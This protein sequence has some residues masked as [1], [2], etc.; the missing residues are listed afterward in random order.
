M[1]LIFYLLKMVELTMNGD[2]LKH[3]FK[4]IPIK[5]NYTMFDWLKDRNMSL[6]KYLD[7]MQYVECAK[8]KDRTCANFDC[9]NNF[10]L[11]HKIEK[12]GDY[13][14]LKEMVIYHA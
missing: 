14:K 11:L 10:R 12:T 9:R 2:T 7:F 6:E 1:N 5:T 4:P 8:S 3:I 13:G